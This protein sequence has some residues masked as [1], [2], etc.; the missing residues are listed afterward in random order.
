MKALV[1]ERIGPAHESVAC[2]VREEPGA[3]L[4]GKVLIGML[5]MPVNPADLLLIEGRYGTQRPVPFVPGHEGVGR[6]LA[7]GPEV[8]GLAVG[9]V[10]VPMSNS[11]WTERMLVPAS[12]TIRLPEG[13]DPVQA[14][15]LKANPAT[16]WV[17]LRDLVALRPGDW[18]IQNAGNSAV[19][20]F[21]NALA[22]RSGIRTVS[23]VRRAGAIP[24]VAARHGSVFVVD[25]GGDPGSVRQAIAAATGGEPIRLALDAV[26][27]R[28][29][30]L[31]GSVVADGG[32]VACYGLLSG[33][34]CK[35][36]AHDVVFRDVRLRG[37]WLARWFQ[38]ADPGRIQALYA[39][40]AAL[41]ADRTLYAPV[42]GCYRLD[43]VARALAH[44]AG[45]ERNGKVIFVTDDSGLA[46]FH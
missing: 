33:D 10:V 42:A 36:A 26:G 11:C 39:E 30:Q 32:T 22:A 19:G 29:T 16:A 34:A 12:A 24:A 27:G 17:M 46:P 38:A 41:L 14:S 21:V 15:M 2:R 40:L 5:A 31:L 9:D 37:F 20:T 13:V 3:P 45:G 28:A 23:V 18:V 6:V 8:Q 25:D 4:A 43:D 35:L 7:V 44:A 1:A